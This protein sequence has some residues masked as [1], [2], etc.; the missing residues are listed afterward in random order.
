MLQGVGLG[1]VLT[2]VAP[3]GATMRHQ[4]PV[5]YYRPVQ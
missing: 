5:L 2:E 1:P 4:T 3:R